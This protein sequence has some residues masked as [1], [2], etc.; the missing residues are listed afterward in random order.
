MS[1]AAVWLFCLTARW[2]QTT[3]PISMVFILDLLDY[4]LLSNPYKHAKQVKNHRG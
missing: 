3:P 2:A 1:E 4:G